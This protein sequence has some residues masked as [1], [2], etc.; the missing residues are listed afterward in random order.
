MAL[1]V[2]YSHHMCFKRAYR[3][4]FALTLIILVIPTAS[5]A[6]PPVLK[7]HRPHIRAIA[8]ELLFTGNRQ[9]TFIEMLKS[10]RAL[11]LEGE[12]DYDIFGVLHDLANANYQEMAR[13]IRSSPDRRNVVRAQGG[14]TV[15]SPLNTPL[16]DLMKI[17]SLIQF[18]NGE[19]I[20][21][22]GSGHGAPALFFAALH[23]ET[24]WL[25][26]ELVR[27]KVNGA[28]LVAL[29]LELSNVHFVQGDLGAADFRLPSADT[30]Y[31]LN[32]VDQKILKSL[33]EQMHQIAKTRK[34]RIIGLGLEGHLRSIDTSWLPTYKRYDPANPLEASIVIFESK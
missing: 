6:L 27:E 11:E 25:G 12:G 28:E 30:Y 24:D 17:D 16:A 33:F 5:Q 34:I 22:L 18:K 8:C 2:L 31:L 20:V 23:P 3:V 7:H 14:A 29:S 32:P 19:S 21:D 10:K 4:I 26:I 15:G 1:F 9:A 13:S